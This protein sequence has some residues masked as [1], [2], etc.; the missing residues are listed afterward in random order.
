MNEHF[1]P[2][3]AY[4]SLDSCDAYGWAV[5]VRIGTPDSWQHLVT[6][7]TE[8]EAISIR[9]EYNAQATQENAR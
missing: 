8:T 5:A 1:I 4:I 3:V 2:S 6:C 7:D 9:N